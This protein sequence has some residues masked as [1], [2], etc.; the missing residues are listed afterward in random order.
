[1]QTD[2]TGTLYVVATPIGNMDDITLRALAVLKQVDKIA[3]EDSRHSGHLLKHHS[4]S[5]PTISLHDFNEANRLGVML[6]YLYEGLSI[7]LISD[8]GTPL[9]SD[10]GFKLVKAVRAE[11][12]PVVPIPGPCAAVAALS[13]AGMPTDRFAFEGFLPPKQEAC[14]KYLKGLLH[15][16][17]TM[18]FYEAPHR[19]LQVL[20]WMMEVFG[21]ERQ[22]CIARELTKKYETVQPGTLEEL[23]DY[24]KRHDK[25]LCGEIVLLV[26]GVNEKKSETKEVVPE[27][28]LDLLLEQMPVKQAATL[29]SKITGARKNELYDLALVKKGK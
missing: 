8:A 2:E 22:A 7:A 9:I 15:E 25:E 24:Y 6:D 20:E 12:I 28:V 29:A 17:R 3:V 4:I 11:G 16:S 5:K 18:V 27:Q 10:P 19:L 23:H 14:T 21:A 1:M 13:V 26:H